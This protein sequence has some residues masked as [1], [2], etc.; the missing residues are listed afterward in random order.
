[1]SYKGFKF[2]ELG[3]RPEAVRNQGAASTAE[4]RREYQRLYRVAQK[5]LRNF[6]KAGYTDTK[7]YMYNV[8]RIKPLSALSP[9]DLP[10][11]LYDV[12]NMLSNERG[13]VAGM[14][15]WERE[16]VK[17]FHEKG[18]NF[19][20]MKNFHAFNQY[21]EWYRDNKKELSFGSERVGE[22]FAVVE[23]LGVDPEKI[24]DDFIFWYQQREKLAEM[25]REFVRG[26]QS[27]A[28]I[29]KALKQYEA[30]KK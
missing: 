18:W 11:A 5:R 12:Y 17:D 19:I 29:K 13:S 26:A 24:K 4:Y 16:R 7:T 14:K 3:Y 1:M 25:P 15:A 10:Y 6:E 2:N 21:M 27:T 23:N 22:V 30:K 9:Q 28:D 20:T 8:E